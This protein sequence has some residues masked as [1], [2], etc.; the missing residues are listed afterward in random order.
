MTGVPAFPR[1]DVI[2]R[3][4]AT[5]EVTIQGISYPV[6]P[7][8]DVAT[9]RQRAIGVVTVRAAMV[10]QRPVLVTA[11]DPEGTWPL[12]VHPN[13]HVQPGDAAGAPTQLPRRPGGRVRLRTTDGQTS[14]A[15]RSFLVGRDPHPKR[16][17]TVDVL[18]SVDDP[19]REASKTHARI[20]VDAN[21][22]VTVTD[23]DSTNGTDI[24]LH[25]TR[26]PAPPGHALVVPAGATIRVGTIDIVV[27]DDVL[28]TPAAQT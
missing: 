14:A 1:I 5:G 2:V 4:D 15:G 9:A 12:V 10:L 8:G 25:G 17:E 3:A 26:R 27:V 28:D 7:S 22:A 21:G 24:N 6:P 19:A 16:G 23:R 11:H 20:D 13:G 18:L